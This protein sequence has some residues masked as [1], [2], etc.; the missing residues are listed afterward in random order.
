MVTRS[1]SDKWRNIG[2]ELHFEDSQLDA[3]VKEPGRHSCDDYYMA[4]LRK[5]LDLNN[6]HPIKS[7]VSALR[8]VGKEK[9]AQDLQK[10]RK[11]N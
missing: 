9:Q 6:S 8:A 4:M 2:W 7:L 5:F 11:G 10:L 1:A 3:I